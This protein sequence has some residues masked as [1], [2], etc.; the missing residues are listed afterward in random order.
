MVNT[1]ETGRSTAAL[2]RGPLCSGYGPVSAPVAWLRGS[3]HY[4]DSVSMESGWKVI[5]AGTGL[6]PRV[7]GL[8]PA[9]PNGKG[10]RPPARPAACHPVRF[11]RRM[12]AGIVPV[13][14]DE[15]LYAQ[16]GFLDTLV[17]CGVADADVVLALLTE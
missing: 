17:W 2:P 10:T 16:Q 5:R 12:L 1:V 3:R 6:P 9:G 8:G 15:V 11:C 13:T 7:P 4:Y 14:V